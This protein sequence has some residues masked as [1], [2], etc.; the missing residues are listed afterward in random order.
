MLYL[1]VYLY[2]FYGNFI[3]ILKDG[4]GIGIGAII[5]LTVVV[6]THWEERNYEGECKDSLDERDVYW[7]ARKR[8]GQVFKIAGVLGLVLML[9]PSPKGLAMLGGVY[10]GS[11]VYDKMEHSTLVDKSIKILDNELNKYLD[12]QLAPPESKDT[13]DAKD[14]KESK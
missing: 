11:Q 1:I 8:L 5:I 10:V 2:D 12:A 3:D 14:S 6:A 9:L 13:K 4:F 7:S